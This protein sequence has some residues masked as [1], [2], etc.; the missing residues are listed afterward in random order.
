VTSAGLKL[1]AVCAISLLL[2]GCVLT[3]L[4][5]MPLRVTGS[6]LSVTGAVISVVPVVGNSIDEAFESLD[7]SLDVLAD[8]ID[9]VPI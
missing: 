9:D 7:T 5:S 3:K 8:R 6:L 2:S 1:G 4:V